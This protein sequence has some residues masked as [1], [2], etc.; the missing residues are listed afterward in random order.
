MLLRGPPPNGFVMILPH[1]FPSHFGNVVEQGVV[2][3]RATRLRAVRTDTL[4]MAASFFIR[5]ADIE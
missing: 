3:T 1:L 5:N 4:V 2:I